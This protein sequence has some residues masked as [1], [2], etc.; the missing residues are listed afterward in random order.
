MSLKSIVCR[1]VDENRSSSVFFMMLTRRIF[2]PAGQEENDIQFPGITC[3]RS[4]SSQSNRM[5][6]AE[7][8]SKQRN[9]YIHT[10]LISMHFTESTFRVEN[11]RER[12]SVD[13]YGHPGLSS[14][15]MLRQAIQFG[16]LMTAAATRMQNRVRMQLVRVMMMTTEPEGESRVT[17]EIEEKGVLCIY[18][19]GRG[20]M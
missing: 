17:E 10:H 15:W 6:R 12:K 7:K 14:Q 18:C 16:S 13:N 19:E 5:S 3:N 8:K 4:K 11:V 9:M 1:Q 2:S 20:K